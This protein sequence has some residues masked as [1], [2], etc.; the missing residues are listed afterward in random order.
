MVHAPQDPCCIAYRRTWQPAG[1]VGSGIRRT[2]GTADKEALTR[3]M[4]DN[5]LWRPVPAS[6][7]SWAI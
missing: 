2:F 1:H 7:I 6:I 3:W 5:A 4:S